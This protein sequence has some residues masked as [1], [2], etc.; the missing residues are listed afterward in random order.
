M[1]MQPHATEHA[2]AHSFDAAPSGKGRGARIFVFASAAVMVG[3]GVYRFRQSSAKGKALA[4]E[5]DVAKAALGKKASFGV[6]RPVP[7]TWTPAVELTGTLKPWNEADLSFETPGRLVKLVAR[8][9][10][11]VKTGALLGMLDAS[12][13]GAQVGQADA[14]AQAA[15]ASLAMAQD[16]LTRTEKLFESKVV[17]DAVMEQARQQVALAKAQLAAANAGGKLARSGEGMSSLR[18]PFSGVVSRAPASPGAMMSPGMP[19]FRVE[20]VSHFRLSS[21]V[22]E[23]ELDLV[24]VGAEVRV[25]YN[26]HDVPGRV[27]AVVPSLDAATRRAPVEIEVPGGAQTAAI[28]G[29]A[30]VRARALGGAPVAVLRVP[31]AARK[32]G[33]QDQV[34]VVDNGHAKLLRVVRVEDSDGSWLVRA[35]LSPNDE[36]IVSPPPELQDGEAVVIKSGDAL[37]IPAKK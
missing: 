34:F 18:A 32:A 5:R 25:L 29:N 4:A 22:S 23:A 27:T 24:K 21:S 8:L 2:P 17:S 20:D 19:V 33:S 9:G 7:A 36:L 14:Q 10:D 16:N 26:D 31:A 1:S 11:T 35:G 15:T 6:T 30:F 13:A 3:V 12:R 28:P 37:T